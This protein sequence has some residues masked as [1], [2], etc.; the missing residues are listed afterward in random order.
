MHTDRTM[1]KW[2]SKPG[3]QGDTS[4]G[5]WLLQSPAQL[6][7]M[8]SVLSGQPAGPKRG[9]GHILKGWAQTKSRKG[10]LLSKR[11]VHLVVSQKVSIRESRV[12]SPSSSRPSESLDTAPSWS[13]AC[14]R[15]SARAQPFRQSASTSVDFCLS[16]SLH[17]KPRTV[18]RSETQH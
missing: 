8:Y 18:H 4:L 3:S 2:S 11:S 10:T 1:V 16:M 5:P 14:R 13:W 7:S 6:P 9:L 12:L 17:T 15:W